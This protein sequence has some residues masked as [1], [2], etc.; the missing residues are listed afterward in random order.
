MGNVNPLGPHIRTVSTRTGDGSARRTPVLVTRLPEAPVA[1]LPPVG[2]AV[3]WECADTRPTCA[4]GSC[5]AYVEVV[6]T[7]CARHV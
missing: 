6:G 4:T 1:P 5:A 3:R 2:Y 7:C